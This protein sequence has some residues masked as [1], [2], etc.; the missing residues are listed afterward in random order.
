[1]IFRG[2]VKKGKLMLDRRE[3]FD[4]KVSRLEGKRVVLNMEKQSGRRTIA[5]NKYYWLLMGIMETE[6]ETGYTADEWHEIFKEMF[7]EDK[8]YQIAEHTVRTK[9][10]TKK[11]NTKEFSEYIEKIKR[12]ASS[13]VGVVLPDAD[14]FQLLK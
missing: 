14:Y 12:F 5:Q 9:G 2:T 8:T 13:E 10:S 7:L 1:M 11:Q 4:I 6:S 3:D